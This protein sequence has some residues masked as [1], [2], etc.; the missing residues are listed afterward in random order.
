MAD[1][2]EDKGAL[3]CKVVLIGESGV[4]KTSII[5]RY[6]SNTFKENMM[7]TPG[8][9]FLTKNVQFQEEKETIKFEIWDTAG[10][11]KYRSLAKVFYKNAAACVLV[12]DI[13]NKKSFDEIK[14]YWVG[15]IKENSSQNVSK[16]F[17]IKYN[18]IVLVLV[19][20]KS[21]DYLNEAVTD[22]EGKELAKEIDALYHR[23]SA[24]SS[25]ES[26]NNVFLSIGKKFLNP[27]TENTSHL[28]KEEIIQKNEKLIRDQIKG[29]NQG[30]KKRWC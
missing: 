24:K 6:T 16:Y 11:E 1:E 29:N 17:N 3:P 10:Q 25:E 23:T 12:F 22:N 7:A 15:E 8:A 9:N 20:N 21:D 18:L 28:S 5:S 26:V 13:T 19:G 2:E 27:S 14:K 30:K 4:G